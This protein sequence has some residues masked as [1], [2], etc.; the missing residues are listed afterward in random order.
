MPNVN[1]SGAGASGSAAI[2]GTPS[3]LAISCGSAATAVVP[4]GSTV[5][6]NSSIHSLVDS[7]CMWASTNEGVSA[8]PATSTCSCASRS[9][10]PAT[11]PSATARA[12]STHSLVAGLNTRPPVMSRSAGSSPRATAIALGVAWGRATG[13]PALDR[14]LDQAERLGR[15]VEHLAAV[16]HT[17]ARDVE[18]Q[19]VAVR[20]RQVNALDLGM[21]LDHRLAHPVE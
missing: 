9:P 20:Q 16:L 4:C 15:G 18:R 12:V 6:T 7:R 11:K 21:R 19:V 8:A 2:P 10:Q 13:L 1:G 17:E 5:R 3:T 14:G